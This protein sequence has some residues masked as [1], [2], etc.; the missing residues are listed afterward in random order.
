MENKICFKIRFPFVARWE[1]SWPFDKFKVYANFVFQVVFQNWKTKNGNRWLIFVFL[2][3]GKRMALR[4]THWLSPLFFIELEF[5]NDCSW[6]TRKFYERI[7]V[8]ERKHM[9]LMSWKQHILSNEP[10]VLEVSKKKG[11]NVEE[12]FQMNK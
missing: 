11:L 6:K 9:Q 4:Y 7:F 8:K 12:F 5:N 1:N 10:S 3:V 2:V